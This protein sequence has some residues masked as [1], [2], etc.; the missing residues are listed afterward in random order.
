[1]DELIA[2]SLQ[3][4]TSEEE[5]EVLRRWRQET[6]EHEERYRHVAAVWRATR[7]Y[8]PRLRAR[9]P[10][11]ET[12][13][14]EAARRRTGADR[15]WSG[16]ARVAAIAAAVVMGLAVGRW[17]TG[18]VGS[19][20]GSELVTGA[21]ETATA[22]LADGT[23]IRL[24]PESRLVLQPGGTAR[25]VM[26]VGRA[27]FSVARDPK[28]P[29]LVRTSAGDARVLGTR[30]ELSTEERD[31]RLVVLEGRVAVSAAGKEVE[32]GSHQVSHVRDGAA[33]SVVEVDDVW[34]L[35]SW[36]GGFVAFE[37]TPLLEVGRELERRFGLTLRVDDDELARQTVTVWFGDEPVDRVVSVLCQL[38]EATCTIEDSTVRMRSAR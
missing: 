15:G 26:L 30:F 18:P 7:S 16:V 35:L 4:R 13:I 8:E 22:R 10:A 3:G 36:M 20:P 24:A 6:V 5:E 25:E 14:A 17:L 29:F 11:H 32:L 33:P 21:D 38:V 28:R 27:F 12:I 31:L 1:M 9:P 23:V 2:R 37:A 19:D 34:P